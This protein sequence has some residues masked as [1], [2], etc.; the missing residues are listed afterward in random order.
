MFSSHL[1]FNDEITN[2]L[3]ILIQKDS[4]ILLGNFNETWARHVFCE[5]FKKGVY[6]SKFQWL[7]VGMYQ[8]EWWRHHLPPNCSQEQLEKALVGVMVMDVQ[9]LAS[10]DDITVSG[11]VSQ[12]V[13]L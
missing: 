5:A 10:N 6:G 11:R 9:A 13:L 3:D 2:Q 4:R 1:G 12:S 8:E 7:I